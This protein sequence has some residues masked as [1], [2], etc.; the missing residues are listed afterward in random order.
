MRRTLIALLLLLTLGAQAA[1]ATPHS[2][3]RDAQRDVMLTIYNGN[4]GL[5]KDVREARFAQGLGEVQFM[6]VA[7]LIDPTTVHLRS[8]TDAAGLKI[9]EQNYEYDLLTSQKLLEKY[10]GRKVR[11]YQGDGTFHEA[12]LLST[13]GPVFEIGG[14]IHLG[15][16]G[17]LVLPAL[18]ENLVS[19]PTLV[20]LTRS[21]SA[22]PQRVEASYLTGGITWKADYVLVL[23]A[24]DR[25]SDLTGWV[26]I[27]NKSGATYGNAAL[28]LVA[29]DVNRAQ[30]ERR[31]G[32][33][34]EMAAK[35]ASAA[36][37]SRDFKSEG[38]F[39]YHLYTLDGRTTVKDRQTKQLSLLAASDVPVTKQL[40]Y[41]G[42]QEY[43]RN[44]YGVPI[45]NQKVGVYL[46]LKN[47][48]EHRLGLP[49]PKGKVRV[50]KADAAGSQQFV[51]EDWIDHTPRDERVKIKMG[52][53]FDVVGER[54]QTDFRK[55]AA[56]VWEVEWEISLRN[57]KKEAQTVTVIE[58]VP[59]DWQVL[60]STHKHEKI[61][62]HTL[63]YEIPVPR[64]GAAKLVYRVRIRW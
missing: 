58:P 24:T 9:L 1:G 26:T 7:A 40:I 28:K 62:A 50:Y 22:A 12:T 52:N 60:S 46:E 5:V 53:A 25:K 20:W 39:E 19:K 2:I 34:M 30:D 35:S 36:D 21:R 38:F 49:L 43:Y 42:A 47:S 57:H 41:W 23:D 51:G 18:P 11:L 59:G 14:Q 6:D 27:D 37:A 13:S 61:E 63:K 8:L 3:T 10:V 16:T 17:R 33:A 44:S 15:Y 4:L 56:H 31:L 55:L 29:G 45:S 54:K 48:K 32:R 64:D